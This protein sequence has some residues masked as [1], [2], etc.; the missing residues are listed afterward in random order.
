MTLL[1]TR[2]LDDY[3]TMTYGEGEGNYFDDKE[4]RLNEKELH[5]NPTI[6]LSMLS[7]EESNF[8]F[9]ICDCIK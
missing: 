9:N 4:K 5:D 8:I 3:G 7:I 2:R 1:P 6:K